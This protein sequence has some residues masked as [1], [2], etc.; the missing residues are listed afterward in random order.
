M[1]QVVKLWIA[2]PE[3]VSSSPFLIH[4]TLRI[5]SVDCVAAVIEDIFLL[6]IAR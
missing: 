4:V 6:S 5:L 1:A 2:T 3:V